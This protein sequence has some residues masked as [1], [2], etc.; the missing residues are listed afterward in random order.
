MYPIAVLV[1]VRTTYYGEDEGQYPLCRFAGEG[2]VFRQGG[3]STS[4]C[5]IVWPTMNA[6]QVLM[7]TD[8]AKLYRLLYKFSS[9]VDP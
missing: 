6:G 5:Q 3:P 9:G 7:V 4:V 2:D 8:Q 1:L